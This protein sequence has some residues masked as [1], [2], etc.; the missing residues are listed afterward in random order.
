MKRKFNILILFSTFLIMSSCKFNRRYDVYL[1]N[2]K[3]ESAMIYKEIVRDYEKQ[4]TV[5]IKVETAA[6]G[7]Y[8]ETL[9][10]E[11][12]KSSVPTIFIING[13][14]GL[15]SWKDYALNL[16]N[17][18]ESYHELKMMEYISNDN[19]FLRD[20]KNI[21]GVP[22]TI[23]GYGLIYNKSVFDEYFSLADRLSPLTKMED[24]SSY[25]E[26]EVVV[27][28]LNN[29]INKNKLVQGKSNIEKL[30]SVFAP[31]SLKSGSD[32]P[33][34]T[35]L[36]SVAMFYEFN[37]LGDKF[38]GTDT[39]TI[40]FKYNLNMKKMLDLYMKY[41][42][43]DQKKL[44][45]V[46]YDDSLNSFITGKSAIIQQGNWIISTILSDESSTLGAFDV[47]MIPIYMG[48]PYEENYGVAIGTENYFAINKTISKRQINASIDFLNWLYTTEIGQNYL[49]NRL[50]YIPPYTNFDYTTNNSLNESIIKYMNDESLTPVEWSFNYY[51]NEAFKT[52]FGGN[53][54][55]YAIGKQTWNDVV[56]NV[57]KKWKEESR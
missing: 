16:N 54:L 51:P 22:S 19:L 32:W 45:D 55:D 3:P 49:I 34:Q 36:S 21:Y 5:K 24:I 10:V 29:I 15:K 57:K 41:S 26:L 44:G 39:K 35:H 25:D 2:F 13:P 52:D 12:L 33:Y 46:S 18:K 9:M 28:D 30:Q 17:H 31:V 38:L 8:E 23:E 4:A 40:E 53:L 43:Y 50:G 47:G 7:R 42:N 6:S 11:L 56:E 1:L 37:E 27:E 48:I 14:A 20:G